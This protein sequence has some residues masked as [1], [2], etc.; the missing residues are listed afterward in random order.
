[1]EVILNLTIP[2]IDV[3][4]KG[5]K[6]NKWLIILQCFATPVACAFITK[7]KYWLLLLLKC[8]HDSPTRVDFVTIAKLTH[9]FRAI[10]CREQSE[11]LSTNKGRLCNNSQID[12]LN[13]KRL[14]VENKAKLSQ[15]TRA[16][17]ATIAKLT[18]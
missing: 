14:S 1:M 2:V 16:G 10:I 7:S 12:T 17:F 9:Y 8:L 13:S 18:H 3:D 5:M 11:T 4:E 6:W 15:L